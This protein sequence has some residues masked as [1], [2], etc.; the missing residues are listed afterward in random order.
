MKNYAAILY[1][2]K[3]P[4]FLEWL[5]KYLVIITCAT[6]HGGNTYPV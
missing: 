1:I 6:P 5:L 4:I 2:S 3:L